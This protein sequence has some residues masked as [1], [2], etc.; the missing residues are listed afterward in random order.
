MAEHAKCD[1]HASEKKS[2]GR[3]VMLVVTLCVLCVLAFVLVA[4]T[5]SFS[6]RSTKAD[7]VVTFGSV[8]VQTVETMKGPD[9]EGIAVPET[10]QMSGVGPRKPHRAREERR[11]GAGL[12]AREAFGARGGR[13]GRRRACR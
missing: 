8:T 3:R 12:R 13:A 5:V 10:E 11:S 6:A 1:D 2:S 9:G 7:N 4:Q